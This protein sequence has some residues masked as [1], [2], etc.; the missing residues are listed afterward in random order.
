MI[1]NMLSEFW[2]DEDLRFDFRIE[3]WTSDS[4]IQT[5]QITL[6]SIGKHTW[7]VTARKANLKSN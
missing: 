1:L 3:M 4:K 5:Q 2:F 6:G 7:Q